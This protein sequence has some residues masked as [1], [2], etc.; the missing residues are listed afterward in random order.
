MGYRPDAVLADVQLDAM[1]ERDHARRMH[2]LSD[3]LQV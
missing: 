3:E 1:A 2:S